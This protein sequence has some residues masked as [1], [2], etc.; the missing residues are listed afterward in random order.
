MHPTCT[1]CDRRLERY[2][3]R[4]SHRSG[5]TG[6]PVTACRRSPTY[7]HQRHTSWRPAP[8]VGE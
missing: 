4:W 5:H 1:H 6:E 8:D 2:E 3:G 7:E